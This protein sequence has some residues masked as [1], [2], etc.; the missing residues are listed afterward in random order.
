MPPTIEEVRSILP[1]PTDDKVEEVLWGPIS[2]A[3]ARAAGAPFASS[4][5]LL[6]PGIDPEL[7]TRVLAE[8]PLD[9]IPS[10]DDTVATFVA[11]LS[12]SSFLEDSHVQKSGC[13]KKRVCGSTRHRTRN[14]DGA[15][16]LCRSA[17]RTRMT[18]ET[19]C[20]R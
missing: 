18:M 1:P 17:S 8:V 10:G 11:R 12:S 14:R 13:L 9:V 4:S 2:P 6:R 16:G 19:L 7:R 20:Q 5:I 15:R 3:D